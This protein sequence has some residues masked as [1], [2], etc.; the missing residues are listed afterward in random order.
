MS[1]V[2]A[3]P[4]ALRLLA[5]RLSAAAEGLTQTH[6]ALQSGHESVAATWRDE[7]YRAFEEIFHESL[8]QLRRLTGD[9]THTAAYLRRK[10]GP[11]DDY[12][13]RRGYR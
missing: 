5:E 6:A 8:G 12:L 7:K 11:L 2:D 1:G 13:A 9:M 4:E 10:A 3:D